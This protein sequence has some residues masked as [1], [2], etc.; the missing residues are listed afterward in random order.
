MTGSQL[1]SFLMRA[2][3]DGSAEKANKINKSNEKM[4]EMAMNEDQP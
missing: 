4:S 1:C 3:I 2:Y